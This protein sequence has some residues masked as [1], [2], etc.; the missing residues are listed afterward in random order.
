MTATND[1]L[2]IY[3]TCVEMADRVSARRTAANSFFLTI[4][5]GFLATF[6]FFGGSALIGAASIQRFFLVVAGAAGVILSGAWWLLLKSYRDLNAAKFR[7][8]N[9]LER[10]LPA[11]PYTDEWAI[12]QDDSV[13]GWRKRYAEQG[14]VER[15]V[16]V[17]VA[18]LYILLIIRIILGT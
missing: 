13:K 17:V 2:E 5:A 15:I 6:G 8:I 7:V 1:V 12:L 11:H 16:P 9:A 18:C 14:T 10:E 4:H 3:K